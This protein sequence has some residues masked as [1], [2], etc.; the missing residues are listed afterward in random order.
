MKK[1]SYESQK[2]E[3]TPQ[4]MKE[5]RFIKLRHEHVQAGLV[6]IILWLMFNLLSSLTV[7]LKLPPLLPWFIA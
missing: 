4:L 2:M 7:D 6:E 1:L 5:A 3:K